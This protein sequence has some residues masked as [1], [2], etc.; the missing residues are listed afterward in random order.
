LVRELRTVKREIITGAKYI[1]TE[2]EHIDTSMLQVEAPTNEL[3]DA[4][5]KVSGRMDGQDNRQT[6]HEQVTSH[7]YQT[8]PAE[9]AAAM[10]RPEQL[11]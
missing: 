3:Q 1:G 8:I 11:G 10:G 4:L 9:G 5:K 2:L 6:Q 7:R